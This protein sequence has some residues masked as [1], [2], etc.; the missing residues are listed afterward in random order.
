MSKRTP[1][2]HKNNT[3]LML[4]YVDTRKNLKAIRGNGYRFAPKGEMFPIETIM[5]IVRSSGFWEAYT[6][7]YPKWEK[8]YTTACWCRS[9]IACQVSWISDVF[10][11][12]YNLKARYLNVCSQVMAVGCLT[13]I[14]VSCMGPKHATKDTYLIFQPIYMHVSMCM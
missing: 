12:Y 4:F 1:K 5:L 6:Q 2:N 7:T 10:W 3:T 9:M 14:P 11:I 13:F 8:I